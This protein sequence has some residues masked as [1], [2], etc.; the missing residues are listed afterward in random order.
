MPGRKQDAKKDQAWK[1]S[2]AY[3]SADTPQEARARADVCLQEQ[4]RADSG[5][6]FMGSTQHFP[7]PSSP[8][9]EDSVLQAGRLAATPTPLVAASTAFVKGGARRWKWSDQQAAERCCKKSNSN[10]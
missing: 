7:I 5:G 3:T 9:R 10:K 2:L 8:S 1:R 6:E 4:S